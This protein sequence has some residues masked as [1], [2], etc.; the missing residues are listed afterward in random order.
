MLKK[1]NPGEE[2]ERRSTR[3]QENVLRVLRFIHDWL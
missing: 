1:A 3:G 2:I